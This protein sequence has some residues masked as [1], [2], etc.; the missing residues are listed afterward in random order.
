MNAGPRP[1][2]VV[3]L[4][5]ALDGGGVEQATVEIAA[6]LQSAG[7]RASVIGAGGA[8][9]PA[10][11]ATGA[12]HLE[13][14]IGRK[15]LATLGTVGPLRAALAEWRPDIVHVR[16]RLPAWIARLAL[17]GLPG[18]RP[19]LVSTVH[20]LN[21]PGRYSGIMVRADRVIC[22][23]QTVRAHVLRQWPDTPPGRL[24]VIA[25]GIDPARF[26]RGGATAARAALEAEFPQLAGRRV[27]LMPGRGTRLKGHDAALVLLAGLVAA[28]VDALLW[29]PGAAQVGRERY[30]AELYEIARG[31]GVVDRLLVT[32]ARQDLPRLYA[33]ADLVLQLSSRPEALGRTV[34]EALAAGRP[35]LGFDH[36]GVGETLA[37]LWPHGRVPAGDH[38]ALLA[39]ARRFLEAA[40]DVPRYRGPTLQDMQAATLAEY[41]ALAAAA[42]VDDGR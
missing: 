42:V 39:K 41:R 27:L 6:A 34:L 26:P 5:P 9:L 10:L 20:G 3:Q 31:L 18:P 37:A 33:I 32:P 21:S 28:N 36:G 17:R 16:S 2:H 40:P 15:S 25:R 19:R 30:L 24:V 12:R 22:V 1:L 35:V 14:P 23:S 38:V 8:M 11:L 29:L 4:V 13:L 7:H